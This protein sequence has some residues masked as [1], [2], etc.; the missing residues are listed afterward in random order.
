MDFILF[1]ILVGHELVLIINRVFFTF[2]LG[3]DGG[4]F[5]FKTTLGN[6]L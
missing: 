4:H 2:I 6:V 5:P 3:L 1:L